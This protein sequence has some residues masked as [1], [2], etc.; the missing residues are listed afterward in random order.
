MGLFSCFEKQAEEGNH[1][2]LLESNSKE[3]KLIEKCAQI[4]TEFSL[5][6]DKD[7]FSNDKKC[8]MKEMNKKFQILIQHLPQQKEEI[9]KIQQLYGEFYHSLPFKIRLVSN[10][11][12]QSVFRDGNQVQLS[13]FRTALNQLNEKLTSKLAKYSQPLEVKRTHSINYGSLSSL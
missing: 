7:Y 6:S 3:A 8:S 5:R 9:E 13:A 1:Y 4:V 10:R 2:S 12:G 11:R